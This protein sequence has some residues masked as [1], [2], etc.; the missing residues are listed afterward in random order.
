MTRCSNCGNDYDE[1]F[2]VTMAD[3]TSGT[4]DAFEC[5]AHALAPRCEHCGTPVVGHGVRVA[6]NIYCCSHCARE[7]TGVETTDTVAVT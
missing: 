1:T 4:F 7:T 5:A 3:G 2:T 6:D